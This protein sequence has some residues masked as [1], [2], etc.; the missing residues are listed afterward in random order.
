[1]RFR[2]GIVKS[3]SDQII[4]LSQQII[5]IDNTNSLAKEEIDRKLYKREYYNNFSAEISKIHTDVSQKI[6]VNHDRFDKIEK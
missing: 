4:F 1:M 5:R 3:I 2:Q 6:D